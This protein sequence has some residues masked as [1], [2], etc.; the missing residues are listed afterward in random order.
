ME[1]YPE[2][3]REE[4]RK[5]VNGLLASCIG[6]EY[7]EQIAFDED[8]FNDVKSDIEET[9]GWREIGYYSYDD[10][11][12]AIGRVLIDALYRE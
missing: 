5:E 2:I 12:L 9:S 10:V 8:F 6:S 11:R 7:A 1:A 3:D 4:L